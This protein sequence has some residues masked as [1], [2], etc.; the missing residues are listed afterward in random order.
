M[1]CCWL[2]CHQPCKQCT[3]LSG[4]RIQCTVVLGHKLLRE[5][6]KKPRTIQEQLGSKPK[7]VFCTETITMRRSIIVPRGANNEYRGGPGGHGTDSP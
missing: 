5:S 7:L 3:V 4:Q 6:K 1:P 2:G